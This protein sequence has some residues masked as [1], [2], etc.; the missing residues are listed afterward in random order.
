MGG[1]GKV[2][3]KVVKESKMNQLTKIA[4]ENYPNA[5]ISRELGRTISQ[6][7]IKELGRLMENRGLPKSS[8]GILGGISKSL[9][10]VSN[11]VNSMSPSIAQ[12]LKSHPL[13]LELQKEEEKILQISDPGLEK[14]LGD[15]E[16]LA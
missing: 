2:L 9:G 12:L 8:G 5:L 11:S 16:R 1:I 13:L 14:T 6:I 15:M 4:L 3:D 10:G 7:E